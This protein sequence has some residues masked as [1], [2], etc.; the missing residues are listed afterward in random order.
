[1]KIINYYAIP[2]LKYHSPSKLK[3][4]TIIE[5]VCNY[6]NLETVD[7]ESK[8]RNRNLVVARQLAMYFIKKYTNLTLLKIGQLF[9][10]RDHTTVIHSINTIEDFIYIKDGK[11]LKMIYDIESTF[12]VKQPI[13]I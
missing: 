12:L 10:N 4:R 5:N 3:E 7:L 2:G 13:T 1:M 11:F 9:G 6:F 8:C